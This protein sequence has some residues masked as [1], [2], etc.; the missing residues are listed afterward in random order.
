M[1]DYPRKVHWVGGPYDGQ[2][3]RAPQRQ[4]TIQ[5]DRRVVPI[6]WRKDRYYALWDR[7]EEQSD[8]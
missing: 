1:N 5:V 6:M 7:G 3:F 4:P 2:T 8:E